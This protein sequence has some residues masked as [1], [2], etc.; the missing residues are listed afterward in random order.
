MIPSVVRKLLKPWAL[1]ELI[2]LR[3]QAAQQ[4]NASAFEIQQYAR[5]LLTSKQED[6]RDPQAALPVAKRAVKLSGGENAGILDTLAL[7]YFMTGDADKAIDTQE[8]AVSLL[9]P[10]ESQLRTKLEANLAKFRQAARNES[11]DQGPVPAANKGDQS[12]PRADP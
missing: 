6:L 7:A 11:R 8:K 4:A 10:E 12:G 2:A 1:T 9:P 5:V 3:R